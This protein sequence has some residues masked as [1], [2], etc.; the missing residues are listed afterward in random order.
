MLTRRTLILATAGLAAVPL[1][2]RPAAADAT[3][4]ALAFIDKLGRDLTA[5]VNGPATLK[6][7]QAG[8][9][10]IVDRD[11]DVVE[12]ARFC[13]GR[14]WRSAT[15]AQQREYTELF[16]KVL[17]N[18]ITGKVGEYQG[19]S[20]IIGRPQTRDDVVAVSSTVIRPGNAPNKVDWLVSMSTGGPKI[21]DVI[22]EGTSL[23][24]TQR[25]DYSA[26]LARNNNNVQALIDAMRQQANQQS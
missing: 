4:Q 3:D 10:K 11:V 13:L 18:N 14:F 16:H 22:A 26:Y 5:I 6:D 15:P 25:S 21:I 1:A 8:L 23:R 12:V 19:V 24:L 9:E 17:V 20:F 7:K 2:G